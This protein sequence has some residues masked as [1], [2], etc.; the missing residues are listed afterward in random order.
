MNIYNNEIFHIHFAVLQKK[1]KN[2][3]G[4]VRKRVIT[5]LQLLH[6]LLTTFVALSKISYYYLQ[7]NQNLEP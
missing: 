5:V 2:C 7:K 3:K 1:K 4:N 6:T